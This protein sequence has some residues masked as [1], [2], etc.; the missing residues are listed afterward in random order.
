M[1]LTAPLTSKPQDYGKYNYHFDNLGLPSKNGTLITTS[2]VSFCHIRYIHQRRIEDI[3]M[4]N[5]IKKFKIND[6]H[7]KNILENFFNIIRGN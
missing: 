5:K 1:Y 2:H 4:A 6:A 3:R 7:V